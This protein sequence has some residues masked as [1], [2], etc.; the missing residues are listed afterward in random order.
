MTFTKWLT[1]KQIQ[2]KRAS[3]EFGL[4]SHLWTLGTIISPASNFMQ[5]CTLVDHVI[6]NNFSF[7]SGD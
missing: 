3:L 5:I 2:Q 1:A 4:H 7:E 6:G